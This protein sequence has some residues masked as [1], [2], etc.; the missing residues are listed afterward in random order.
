M[1]W[2]RRPYIMIFGADI[3]HSRLFTHFLIAGV[4]ENYQF[5]VNMPKTDNNSAII[6]P[7]YYNVPITVDNL[8]SVVPSS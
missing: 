7:L 6:S 2:Q 4:F 5:L 1:T 3:I 8:I